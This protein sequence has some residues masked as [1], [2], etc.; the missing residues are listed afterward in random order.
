MPVQGVLVAEELIHLIEHHHRRAVSQEA[1]FPA[2]LCKP[3]RCTVNAELSI[4]VDR[5]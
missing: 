5:L 4:P 3:S 2:K 1:P